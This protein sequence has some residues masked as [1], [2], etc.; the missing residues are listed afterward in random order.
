MRRLKNLDIITGALY[1][2]ITLRNIMG[3]FM[4]VI[5][6]YSI[7]EVLD[8]INSSEKTINLCGFKVKI[9]SIRLKTFSTKGVDCI[10]CNAKGAYFKLESS[11]PGDSPHFNLYAINQNGHEVLMTKD[12]IVL[13]SLGGENTIENMSP[14]CRRCNNKRG[15]K[16]ESQNEFIN[17]M[18]GVL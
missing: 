7:Q 15:S 16:F 4:Y 17:Y 1:N 8:M 9:N 11:V 6:K 10:C 12:H 14:M 5:E 3:F 18:K 13:K 2:P